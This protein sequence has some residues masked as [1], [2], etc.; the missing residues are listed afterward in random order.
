MEFT[1]FLANVVSPATGDKASSWPII[2]FVAA[3]A[4]ILAV[5]FLLKKK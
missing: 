1:A 3:A 2:L 4:A 5:L